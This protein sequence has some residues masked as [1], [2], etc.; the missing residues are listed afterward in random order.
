MQVVVLR[1]LVGERREAADGL[2]GLVPTFPDPETWTLAHVLRHHAAERPDAV[3]LDLP[4]ERR[5]GLTPRRSTR[6]SAWPRPVPA[7]A[8]QGDRVILMAPNSSSSSAPGGA[9]RSAAWWRCRSTPTTKATF[10]AT[11][12]TSPR[13]VRRDRRRL[14]RALGRVAEHARGIE[15]FWVIDT[16]TGTREGH[17][18]AAGQRLA[19]AAPGTS[20]RGR[21]RSPCRR[22]GRRIWA[23][24]STPRAPPVRP[25]ASR[26][27]TRS[28]TSSRRSWSP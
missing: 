28:C 3:C 19:G 6:P 2:P 20:C 16:G 5:P 11:N 23:R 8:E 22:R 10:C 25:R 4:E 24:S 26:C 9:P 15:K 12:S 18:A 14:R 1:E 13:P 17:G 21:A 27:R 7:G